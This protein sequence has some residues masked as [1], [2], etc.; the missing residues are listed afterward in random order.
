MER[1]KVAEVPVG[2]INIPTNPPALPSPNTASQVAVVFNPPPLPNS[3]SSFQQGEIARARSAMLGVANEMAPLI[4]VI[5]EQM[6][7]TILAMASAAASPRAIAHVL[8]SP[9]QAASDA[10]LDADSPPP[11]RSM[12][13]LYPA[14]L[15]D[16]SAAR[17]W[18]FF[19][20]LGELRSLHKAGQDEA[21][22]QL[23]VAIVSPLV[24]STTYP[25]GL[26]LQ[27]SP[28]RVAFDLEG[29]VKE[30][31]AGLTG[32][33]KSRPLGVSRW[34]SGFGCLV[35][36]REGGRQVRG[37]VVGSDKR[38]VAVLARRAMAAGRDSTFQR[39]CVSGGCNWELAN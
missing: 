13:L 22:R 12:T 28:S 29:W 39:C 26:R 33:M 14:V 30:A 19:D 24:P 3:G 8:R 18:C 23:L 10:A 17:T 34:G 37:R 2:G 20:R 25:G 7:S 32:F 4:G 31:E 35:E 15:A 36:I 11:S 16:E 21:A 9:D 5:D 27:A 6:V 1:G 38:K